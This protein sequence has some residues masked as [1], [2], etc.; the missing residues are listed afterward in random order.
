MKKLTKFI[1]QEIILS[2][3][4]WFVIFIILLIAQI[5]FEYKEYSSLEKSTKEKL[6]SKSTTIETI[7]KNNFISINKDENYTLYQIVKKW[8]NNSIIIKNNNIIIDYF[9]IEINKYDLENLF[10]ISKNNFINYK[11]YKIYKKNYE[12]SYTIYT[13]NEKNYS[14]IYFINSILLFSLIDI[15]IFIFSSLIAYFFVRKILK[16]FK[17]NIQN[18]KEFTDDINHELKTPL[19]IIKSS[20]SLYI[21]EHWKN[22]Y[23]IDT[24]N[25]SNNINNTLETITDI[26]LSFDNYNKKERIILKNEINNLI[27]IYSKDIKQ[28]NIKINININKNTKINIYKNDLLVCI[29]NIIKNA[30][31]YSKNKWKIDISYNKNQIKIEDNWIWIDKKNLNKIF[32][33]FFSE[34]NKKWTWIWLSI[35]KKITQKN[36]WVISVKSKKGEKTTF[37]IQL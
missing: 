25:A 3:L 11:W 22:E 30:I 32:N 12:K 19:S 27:K 9:P 6:I 8:L 36:W 24:I 26:A 15:V 21:K 20:L 5:F 2:I 18:L 34:H 29:S 23:I 37:I 33:R 35:I 1:K 31:K 28:K 13:I 14:Y 10:Y 4:F 7:I 16:E 17:N